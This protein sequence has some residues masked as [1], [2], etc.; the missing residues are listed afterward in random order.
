MNNDFVE[1]CGVSLPRRMVLQ[2]VASFLGCAFAPDALYAA[3]Q[4]RAL[5]TSDVLG[6]FYRFGAPLF[7]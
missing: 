6:P 2:G 7:S 3:A 1:V 5:T 4:S